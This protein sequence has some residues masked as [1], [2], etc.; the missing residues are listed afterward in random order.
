MSRIRFSPKDGVGRIALAAP[1]ARN[2]VDIGWCEDFSA[3]AKACGADASLRVVLIEA[4]GDF[5]SV[6]GDIDHF[7]A[8]R[9]DLTPH[10]RRMAGLF[11]EGLLALHHGGLP[12]VAAVQGLAAGGGFSLALQADLILA[13]KSARF[14]S[15]YSSSGLSPDG[16]LTYTLPRMVG[17]RRAFEIM[18]L[19]PVMDAETAQRLGIVARIFAD[20]VFKT[21][22]EACVRRLAGMSA[23]ALAALKRL[24][25]SSLNN[26]LEQQ[27]SAEAEAVAQLAGSAETLKIL[28]AFLARRG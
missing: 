9:N 1:T 12:V 7:I 24:L 21:E 25:A 23:G 20:D 13:A 18:A 6:G 26:S 15:A 17:T 16:G 4:D 22:V 27:F 28:E 3:A 2:A 11:H 5:F 10:V 19:N 8:H 14:V